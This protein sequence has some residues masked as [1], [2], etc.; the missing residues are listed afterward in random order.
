MI[1]LISQTFTPELSAAPVSFLLGNAGDKKRV[2]TVIS[3]ELFAVSSVEDP[4][5]INHTDGT[6]GL[7]WWFDPQG[8]FEDFNI[9]DTITYMNR[10]DASPTLTPFTIVD[11][12]DGSNIQVNTNFPLTGD[13][14]LETNVVISVTTQVKSIK[15]RYNF[16][17]NVSNDDFISKIDGISEQIFVCKN[18]LASDTVPEAMIPLGP[19]T[20][21]EGLEGSLTTKFDGTSTPVI[22]IEGVAIDTGSTDGVYKSQF[23]IIHYVTI[24]KYLLYLADVPPYRNINCLKFLTQIDALNQYTNPNFIRSEVFSLIE[25]NVGFYDENFATGLTNYSVS[26]V[27]Y[28]NNGIISSI[29]LDTTETDLSFKINNTTDTPFSDNNT[30]FVIEI[31]KVPAD[32]TEYQ[33]VNL[34]DRNFLFD[35]AKQT[36]GS[37]A[38][39][40]DNYG[41]DYQI[42]K[43]VSSLFVNSG[44][45]LISAKIA[46]NQIVVD[47]FQGSAN[48]KYFIFVTIQ[49]H[50]LATSLSDLIS[51]QIDQQEF[52]I[53]TADPTMIVASNIFLR[54]PEADPE[55]EGYVPV[56]AKATGTFNNNPFSASLNWLIVDTVNNKTIGVADDAGTPLATLISL[57]DSI[58]NNTP[59]GTIFGGFPAFGNAGFTASAP[60][61][62]GLGAYSVTITAPEGAAYN[63]AGTTVIYKGDVGDSQGL[64]MTGGLDEVPIDVFPQDELVACT[65]FYIESNTREND[66]IKLVSVETK[67]KADDGTSQFDLDSYI[68]QLS[69]YPLTGYTQ[70]FDVQIARSFHIPIGTIR[71]YIEVQRRN[72]LDTGTRKYFSAHYPFLFRWETWTA[73]LGVDASFF[74]STLPNNGFNE[75]WFHYKTGSWKIYYEIVIKATKN[76]I[77]QEYRL[78]QEINPNDYASNPL[79]T[80]KDTFAFKPEYLTELLSGSGGAVQLVTGNTTSV[81]I[82]GQVYATDG[83]NLNY[84]YKKTLLVA[85]FT[86][87]SAPLSPVVV[88][89]VEIFEQGGVSGKRRFSSKYVADSDTW[90]SSIDG[91]GKVILYAYGNSIIAVCYL[92]PAT[93][94]FPTNAKFMSFSS[95]IYEIG[96]LLTTDDGIP[97]TNDDGIQLSV[98]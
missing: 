3:V 84:L 19:L 95:R 82:N 8:Q 92:D 30:K 38:V 14:F 91:S 54:H 71:K 32:F 47:S 41:T 83:D 39:N 24:P 73:A 63:G 87:T 13:N 65:N 9:G 2:E 25:G 27:S 79:Y 81:T 40:G 17:E 28:Y 5:T 21:Q 75:W 15:Y 34:L 80:L 86:K 70:Q 23:K 22:T 6:V 42:L 10:N 20:W 4:I 1:K 56:G 44:Q 46:M 68:T 48:P 33:N 53:I 77:L 51:L 37:A 18:K 74:D 31:F 66:E 96:G 94:N 16:L 97:L 88:M 76:D 90:F 93:L 11:K 57:V 52:T 43:G 7:G 26:N 59:N 12:I 72:D 45:I 62:A 36:V 67:I 98:D 85:V 29:Q 64:Y 55:T 60:V 89:D 58:N 61:P 50:T 78:Q 49:D 69:A 35:R